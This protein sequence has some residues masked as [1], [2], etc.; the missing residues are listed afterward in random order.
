MSLVTARRPRRMRSKLHDRLHVYI[1][2]LMQYIYLHDLPVWV[3]CPLHPSLNVCCKLNTVECPN[4]EVLGASKIICYTGHFIVK[5]PHYITV[6][7][8]QN[9]SFIIQV[10]S[11]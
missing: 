2:I 9:N 7:H 10:I 6:E 3:F 8:G 1:C 4:N 11:L 5:V